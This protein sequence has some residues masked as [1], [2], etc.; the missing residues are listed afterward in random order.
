MSADY[1]N[2]SQRQQWQFT[3]EQLR[4]KRAR[5][6]IL[7]QQL[8]ASG[9]ILPYLQ[10]IQYDNHMRI[11]LHSLVLRLGRRL[12]LRSVPIATAEVYLLRFLLNVSIKEIN[13]YLLVTTCLYL[14]C[15]VEECP[16]HIR[17][18]S[19]EARNLW[20]EYIPHDLTK[21][22]EFEFYL[23]EEMDNYMIIHN[24]HRSLTQIKSILAQTNFS[25]LNKQNA[26]SN[27]ENF[28]NP[29]NINNAT[30]SNYMNSS[31]SRDKPLDGVNCLV[32]DQ[33]DLQFAW[34]ILNDIYVTDLPLL[35]PPHILALSAI[36]TSMI[37]RSNSVKAMNFL[38]RR[39]QQQSVSARAAA[40]A[41]N[42]PNVS[43]AVAH[44]TAA[45]RTPDPVSYSGHEERLN[46][47]TNFIGISNVDLNEI[48]ESIQ[49]IITLYEVWDTYDE[50]AVKKKV[51][52]LFSNR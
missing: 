15:K 19:N 44:A 49:E 20:P 46:V 36:Y 42:N 22:A 9:A 32:L 17:N 31:I 5:L 10:D 48:I 34:S 26:V 30:A 18:I 1:W 11:F 37:L 29:N 47:L 43:A 50:A 14:A 40:I 45:M 21:I 38:H 24:P 51:H 7:E 25:I 13:L 16:Q 4:D 2:S 23:I 35:F 3:R 28:T 6:D 52:R 39:S 27:I 12:L 33:T 41:A 8:V